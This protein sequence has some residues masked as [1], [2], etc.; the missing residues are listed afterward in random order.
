MSVAPSLVHNVAVHRPILPPTVLC[1][2]SCSDGTQ[3]E[4]T[5]GETVRTDRWNSVYY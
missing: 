2:Y 5:P 3:E 1:L 4:E